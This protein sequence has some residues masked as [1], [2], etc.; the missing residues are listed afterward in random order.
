[1]SCA[2]PARLTPKE[3]GTWRNSVDNRA[4]SKIIM[5]CRFSIPRLDDVL[6]MMVGA[7]IFSRINFKSS[8]HQAMIRPGDEWK[9]DFKAK[10]DLFD[11]VVM[12]FEPPNAPSIFMSIMTLVL[13]TFMENCMVTPKEVST[14]LEEMKPIVEWSIPTSIH[15]VRNFY[16][17]ATLC[18]KFIGGFSTLTVKEPDLNLINIKG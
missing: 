16:G 11:W 7:T 10:S 13:G 6:D 9:T 8:N 2:V 5:E 1:M 15:K 4:M 17:L 12:P 3:D 18:R 14:G